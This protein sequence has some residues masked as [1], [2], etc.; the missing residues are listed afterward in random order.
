MLLEENG[1][2]EKKKV[3]FLLNIVFIWLKILED[4]KKK[5]NKSENLFQSILAQESWEKLE[6]GKLHYLNSYI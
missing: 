3:R 6:E 2:E 4:K 1:G 5:K